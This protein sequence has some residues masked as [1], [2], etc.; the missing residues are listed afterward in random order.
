MSC[1]YN[2]HCTKCLKIFQK[3]TLM[4][5]KILNS[6]FGHKQTMNNYNMNLFIL[7]C[8]RPKSVTLFVERTVYVKMAKNKCPIV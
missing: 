4:I 7:I 2:G 6:S 3:N 1:V 5:Y 8:K